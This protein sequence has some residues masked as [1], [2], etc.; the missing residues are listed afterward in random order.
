MSAWGII[1]RRTLLR[2]RTNNITDHQSKYLSHLYFTYYFDF[3]PHAVHSLYFRR[4]FSF[5]SRKA[6]YYR[7]IA[8][9]GIIIELIIATR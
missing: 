5:S 3:S 2:R 1:M 9:W 6:G 4:L 8:G 7:L